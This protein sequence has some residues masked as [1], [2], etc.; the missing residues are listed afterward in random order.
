MAEGQ[1]G[2]TVRYQIHGRVQGV[3]FRW[4]VR[5]HARRLGL[6]GTVRN[7]PSGSVQVEASGPLEALAELEKLISSGPR[8]AIVTKVDKNENMDEAIPV[9]GFHI[10]E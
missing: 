1:G 3:G 6:S 9:V 10:R 7:L 4:F 8:G 2:V 5:E